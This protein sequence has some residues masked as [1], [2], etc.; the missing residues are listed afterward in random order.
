M[1]EVDKLERKESVNWGR[2]ESSS[3]NTRTRTTGTRKEIKEGRVVQQ[4]KVFKSISKS[5]FERSKD[6][7]RGRGEGK[8]MKGSAEKRSR[9]CREVG[10][11]E[12]LKA[13]G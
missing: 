11:W 4:S 6:T 7:G 8:R 5:F 12:K 2:S 1:E 13:R 3:R 9:V 10:A